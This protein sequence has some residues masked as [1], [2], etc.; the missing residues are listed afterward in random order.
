MLLAVR[1]H[2]K[3]IVSWEGWA[4]FSGSEI[5]GDY[6][7]HFNDINFRFCFMHEKEKCTVIHAG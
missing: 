6:N 2:E 5:H 7:R 1:E 4:S 3:E